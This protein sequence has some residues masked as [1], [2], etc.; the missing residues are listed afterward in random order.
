MNKKAQFYLVAIIIIASIFMGF[1]TTI[2]FGERAETFSLVDLAEEL[3]IEKRYLLDYISYNQLNDDQTEKIFINFSNNYIDKIGKNKDIFF[4]FGKP[5]SIKIVGHRLNETNI[6]ID[7]ETG[8]SSILET[9]SFEKNYSTFNEIKIK[10]EN[11]EYL[12]DLKE[13][14]NF[15]YLV[16]YLSNKERYIVHG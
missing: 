12:F 2:N 15:Y 4:I 14:Q 13:E 8:Y 3:N 11:N 7:D 9:N 5:G 1:A 6:S 10:L 16:H